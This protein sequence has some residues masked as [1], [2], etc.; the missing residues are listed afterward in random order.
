MTVDELLTN[1]YDDF[2]DNID[3]ETA[4]TSVVDDSG[5]LIVRFDDGTALRVR[6]E[7]L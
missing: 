3:G 2:S 6:V 7:E 1:L 5:S 4:V